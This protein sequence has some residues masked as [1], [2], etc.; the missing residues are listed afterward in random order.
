MSFGSFAV[1]TAIALPF[2]TN[3]PGKGAGRRGKDGNERKVHAKNSTS[4]P[5]GV[6]A[7]DR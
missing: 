7:E 2:T 3:L 6:G 5:K 1:N 4:E